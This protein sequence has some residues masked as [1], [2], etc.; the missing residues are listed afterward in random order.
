MIEDC[1]DNPWRT[2]AMWRKSPD[3]A[4]AFKTSRTG[5]YV[6]ASTELEARVWL[7]ANPGVTPCNIHVA[8][9]EIWSPRPSNYFE[10]DQ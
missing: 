9:F 1:R 3:G 7:A 6:F 8:C 4:I 2:P 10:R 5:W